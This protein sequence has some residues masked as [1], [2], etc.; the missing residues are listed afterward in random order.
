MKICA[1]GEI[2]G[3][4][5]RQDAADVIDM[6]VARNQVVDIPGVDAGGFEVADEEAHVVVTLDRPA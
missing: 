5:C 3:A 4:V 2:M 1:L 6:G